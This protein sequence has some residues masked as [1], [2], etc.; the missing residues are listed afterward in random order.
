[1]CGCSQEKNNNKID[2]VVR[3]ADKDFEDLIRRDTENPT[4]SNAETKLCCYNN[5][6]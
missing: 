2:T 1:M 4:C 3:N 6:S 5:K